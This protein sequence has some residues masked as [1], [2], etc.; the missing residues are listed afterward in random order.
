M[1]VT[2]PGRRTEAYRESS[3]VRELRREALRLAPGNDRK[4]LW[5]AMQKQ[6]RGERKR[7]LHNKLDL[8][9]SG[10]WQAKKAA[11]SDKH[12]NSWELR[13]LSEDDWRGDLQ[14]QFLAIFHKRDVSDVDEKFQ[15]ILRDLSRRCKHASWIPFDSA[16]LKAVR[17]K[18][19]NNKACGPDSISYE[20][21][22]ILESTDYW[23]A[24][25]LYLMNDLL[26]MGDIPAAIER[27][28]T[29][30]LAKTTKPNSWGDTRPITLS[31]VLLRTFSQLIINRV[32]CHVQEPSR[33]QWSRR[34]RQGAELVWVLRKVCRTSHDWGIPM[35]LAKLDIRKAFDSGYQEALAGEIARDVGEAGD[36]P[37]EAKAWV[38]L[39]KA[40]RIRIFFRGDTFEITQSNGV[41]QGSPDSPIAFGRIVARTLDLSLQEAQAERPTQGEPPPEHGG[42]YMDDTYIWSTSRAHMQSMLC[43]LCT[44]LRPKGLEVHPNKTEIIANDNEG[45][46]FEIDGHKVACKGPDHVVRTLGSPLCFRG[47]PATLVAEM[48]A[49]SRR[50]FNKHRGTLLSEARV[51]DRL[52]MHTI[53]VRQ[54]ALWCC[55]TWPCLEF[56]LKSANSAQLQERGMVCSTRHQRRF[57]H[58]IMSAAT[59][60]PPAC[61][62]SK[63]PNH[64]EN[65]RT[66][67]VPQMLYSASRNEVFALALVFRRTSGCGVLLSPGC[68]RCL[69]F[70]FA[71]TVSR[72]T[73]RQVTVGGEDVASSCLSSSGL[74]L[75]LASDFRSELGSRCSTGHQTSQRTVLPLLPRLGGPLFALAML[76]QRSPRSAA[77]YPDEG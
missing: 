26:Y 20:A 44:N 19:K 47:T 17:A 62:P 33:L 16:E 59:G 77:Q 24:K 22:K 4:Q 67:G 41:R 31:S 42:S 63:A 48:Q 75:G 15:V 51:K 72:F 35:Y 38:S 76:H 46:T 11:D 60:F 39:L 3:D 45:A 57:L 61:V 58:L 36:Q 12:S 6:R 50:A 73:G 52:Q 53:L 30:L 74:V 2:K 5:K 69:Y 29:V 49:R 32:S 23:R 18:W 70:T 28:I 64:T 66:P 40:N 27:G 14:K 8:A 1:H 71:T 37:W 54:S 25:I 43:C 7:W 9:G 68:L 10:F 56:I 21:L 65:V 34:H 55:E 13:L